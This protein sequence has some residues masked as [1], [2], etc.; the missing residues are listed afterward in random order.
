MEKT[1]Q[2]R[3]IESQNK[4][5]MLTHQYETLKEE[6]ESTRKELGEMREKY[7]EKARQ[8]RKLAELYEQLKKKYGEPATQGLPQS[9]RLSPGPARAPSLPPPHSFGHFAPGGTSFAHNAGMV[10]ANRPPLQQGP[11][12]NS[13]QQAFGRTEGSVFENRGQPEDR[14]CK[15]HTHAVHY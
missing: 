9:P 11:L 6:R 4:I 5:S 3:M 8:K 15:H 1:Y 12:N 10:G 2:E 7:Q 13:R 14:T